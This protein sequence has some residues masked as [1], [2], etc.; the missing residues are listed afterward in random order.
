M[1]AAA[2]PF[3][4]F[5]RTGLSRLARAGLLTG[6]TDGLF[7]SVLSVAAY[8]STV[9][10]L[11]QGVASTLLGKAAI[12]GGTQTALIGVLMHFGVAF[13][14]SAVFLFLVSRSAWIR[15]VLSAPRGVVKVAAVYGPCIWL[16]MSLAVIP[17]LLHRPPT[18]TIRWWV[19][20][21]GHFPFV[22]MPIV[23]SIGR[24]SLQGSG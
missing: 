1:S 13:G 5:D 12:D 23:A 2:A 15:A 14:W 3:S 24:G 16:I 22:G 6:V 9:E 18:I 21:I 19:Q 10:R 17:L 20:L 8:H 7:S 11:F 4:L